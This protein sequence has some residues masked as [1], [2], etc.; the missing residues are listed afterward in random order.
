MPGEKRKEKQMRKLIISLAAAAAGLAVH[1]AAMNWNV[2]AVSASADNALTGAGQYVA[3]FFATSDSSGS[4]STTTMDAVLAEIAKGSAGD[5]V[6]LAS[7]TK[8]N[9]YANNRANFVSNGNGTFAAG[10][11]LSGFV[12]ILDAADLASAKNYMIAKTSSGKTELSKSAP[13][14]GSMLFS[15][16]SQASNT[17]QAIPE[18]TSAMLLV[19]GVA[20]L[21]LK[22]KH[23]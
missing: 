5:I 23:V 2:T 13:T 10:T 19:L 9:T 22:R 1:A 12:L 6:S 21:A 4:L 8:T 17:W 7:Y 18:P 3:Y 14:N 15:Y 11:T 16:G 20:A